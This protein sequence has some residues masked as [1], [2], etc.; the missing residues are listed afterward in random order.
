MGRP[1]ILLADD[2]TMVVEAFKKLLEPE[3]EIVGT[4]SDGQALVRLAPAGPDGAVAHENVGC[5]GILSAV[6]VLIAVNSRGVAVL[7]PGS[8]RKGVAIGRQR[9]RLTEVV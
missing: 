5:T 7:S 9:D 2:H 8:D 6:I 3:F 1:R 4:V